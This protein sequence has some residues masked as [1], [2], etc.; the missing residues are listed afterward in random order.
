MLQGK[1]HLYYR[2]LITL[3]TVTNT[4]QQSLDTLSIH[5]VPAPCGAGRLPIYNPVNG[6]LSGSHHR[7]R[8]E[9]PWVQLS[10]LCCYRHFLPVH[11]LLIVLTK[12]NACW[13]TTEPRVAGGLGFSLF[14][15]EVLQLIPPTRR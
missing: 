11:L 14:V 3:S 4:S 15:K 13:P 9:K 5:L 1:I 8:L 12:N 7:S 6:L 10:L 2:C